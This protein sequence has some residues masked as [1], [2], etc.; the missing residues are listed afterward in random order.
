MSNTT[1]LS[2]TGINLSNIGSREVITLDSGEKVT[3]MDAASRLEANKIYILMGANSMFMEKEKFV[4]SY[5]KVVDELVEMH[6][7]ATIYVQSILPVTQAYEDNRPEFA[8]SIIDDYNAGLK[9][10][11]D[12]ESYHYLNVAEV[13]KDE[14][15]A[16]PD[17][18]SPK[19]GMHFTTSW[20]N[21]W[22]DY[23]RENTI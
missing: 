2:Y 7:E 11:C 12:G 5:K 22:F 8:N 10:M 17:I 4:T 3:I 19:D 1:V 15:G 18:A 21:I 20:Y 9:E 13:F 14:T 6:P 16:L 23:L